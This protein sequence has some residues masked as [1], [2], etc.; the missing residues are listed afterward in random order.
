MFGR[1]VT[2]IPAEEQVIWDTLEYA[3]NKFCDLK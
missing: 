2:D 3:W 1:K